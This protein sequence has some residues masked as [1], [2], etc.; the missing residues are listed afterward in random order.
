MSDSIQTAD[1]VSGSCLPA[2][3]ERS[4][5][6]NYIHYLTATLGIFLDSELDHH[7][8]HGQAAVRR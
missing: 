8:D 6:E 2:A 4:K 3:S 5:I 7:L 1:S